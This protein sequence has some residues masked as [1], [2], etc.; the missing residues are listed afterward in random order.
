M[1]VVSCY[2]E[3]GNDIEKPWNLS[4]MAAYIGKNK[5]TVQ[6]LV[7]RGQLPRPFRLGGESCWMPEK[8]REFF[9]RRAQEAQETQAAR[10]MANYDPTAMR[11]RRARHSE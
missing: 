9:N 6:R 4:H 2:E 3:E 7:R 5:R 11:R 10:N 1:S 8:V